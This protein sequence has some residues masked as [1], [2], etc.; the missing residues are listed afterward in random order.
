MTE[1][2][3]DSNIVEKLRSK[4]EE[5]DIKQYLKST[6]GGYTKNSVLDYLNLLR[7]QHQAAAETFARNQQLLFEEKEN[8]RKTADALKAKLLRLENEHRELLGSIK[9]HEIENGEAAEPDIAALIGRLALVE[10]E[11]NKAVS[12]KSLLEKQLEHQKA[13]SGELAERFERSEQEKLSLKELVKA[14]AQKEKELK[15]IIFRLSNT[16]TEKD[17]EIGFLQSR[18]SEGC[19]SELNKKVN[20]LTEQLNMQAEV[21]TAYNK[22][23]SLKQ[24]TIETLTE[25]NETLRKRSAELLKTVEDLNAQNDKHLAAGRALTEQLENEYRRSIAL[26]IERSAATMDRLEAVKKLQDAGSRI[27]LLEM[28]LNKQTVSEDTAAVYES[29]DVT[30]TINCDNEDILIASANRT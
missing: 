13:E 6:L 12:E 30:D 15:T 25:E 7:K 18:L 26:I 8:L 11:L 2:N 27:T 28:Q 14:Q 1:A 29:A 24:Q 21:L 16:V 20:E 4:V 9:I 19:I 22:D 3:S 17:N 23:S 10:D 5:S